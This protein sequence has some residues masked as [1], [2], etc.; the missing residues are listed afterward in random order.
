MKAGIVLLPGDGIGPEV[1]RAAHRVL[2][3]I[4]RLGG[5]EFTFTTQ[6]IG[7]CSIDASGVALTPEVL[8]SC[9]KADA[10][11]LGAVG[12]PRWDNPQAAVRPEQGLLALRKGLSLYANLRPVKPHP[13]LLDA[14]RSS[15]HT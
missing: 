7:G 9:K 11:L 13:L 15:Q 3:E 1:A 6:L 10:V 8:D 5:H 4:A 2:T 12:G 14:T